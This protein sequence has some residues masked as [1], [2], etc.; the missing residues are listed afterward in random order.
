VSERAL[1]DDASLRRDDVT[2]TGDRA[3]HLA[4]VTR[5]RLGE[6][7]TL[8]DGAGFERDA[9]VTRVDAREVSL[10]CVSPR[11]PG[12]T[13]DAARVTWL[14]GVPKGDKL[15]TIARQATELGVWRF[16]PVWTARSV[17]RER[18]DRAVTRHERL[19]RVVEEAARQCH[20]ADLPEV[21]PACDLSAALALA[22]AGALKLLAW[23][24]AAR[25]LGALPAPGEG[26]VTVLVGPEGGIADSE[27]ALAEAAGFAPISLG[28]RI[29]RTETVA[30]A[31]L[32]VL[33][34]RWGDLGAA[35]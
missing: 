22:P 27:A 3:H 11:R 10:R 23:E 14:Q 1:V 33:S 32:A 31:L 4:R 20:R 30:P 19:L 15:E 21:L 12:V 5:V 9:E 16:V 6:R 34:A 2:L 24:R 35:G 7:V 13:A 26:G 29:L 28:R 25:P 18:A 17:P 8:F